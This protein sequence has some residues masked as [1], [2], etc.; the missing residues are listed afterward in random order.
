MLLGLAAAPLRAQYDDPANAKKEMHPSAQTA[1]HAACPW[2]SEGSAA[3]ALGGDVF[4]TVNVANSN[5]G[6]CRFSRQPWSAD[7]LEIV[8][9]KTAMPGCPA[10]A[11]QPRGI[12]NEAARCRV[13][14]S[15]PE[16]AEMIS[17]RVRDV[18]FTVT[19]N[20]PGQRKAQNT[21]DDALEQLAEQVAGSLY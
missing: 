19:L 18:H 11:P 2:L 4:V 7:S 8:V 10:G 16:S 13:P 17:S 20:I 1:S 14:G 9:G 12:G 21:A 6:S 3:H 15:R 5:E